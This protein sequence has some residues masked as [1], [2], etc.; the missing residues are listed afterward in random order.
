MGLYVNGGYSPPTFGPMEKK[1]DMGSAYAFDFWTGTCLPVFGLGIVIGDT[2]A[3][4]QG[5]F[6]VC[7]LNFHMDGTQRPVVNPL[8]LA[9]LTAFA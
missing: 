7:N 5:G 8:Q 9:G 6:E 3:S 4:I 1:C 2:S